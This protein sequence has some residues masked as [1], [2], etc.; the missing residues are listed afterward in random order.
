MS[1]QPRARRRSNNN[2]VNSVGILVTDTWPFYKT[3]FGCSNFKGTDIENNYY[4]LRP[5]Y[6]NC[7]ELVN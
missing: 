6:L 5:I 1:C 2:I 4:L 7:G 3:N